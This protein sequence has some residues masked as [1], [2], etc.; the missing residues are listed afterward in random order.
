MQVNKW[1]DLGVPNMEI[2]VKHKEE[3]H[4]Y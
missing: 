4:C 1:F 2:G 3:P